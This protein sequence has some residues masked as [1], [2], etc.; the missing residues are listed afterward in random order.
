MKRAY[1]VIKAAIALIMV[2]FVLFSFVF[3]IAEADHSCAGE[4]CPICYQL[5]VCEG[6]LKSALLLAACSAAALITAQ[7]IFG[8]ELCSHSPAS[9]LSPVDLKVKL[10]D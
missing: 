8:A 1:R 6:F 5:S 2:L 4:D 10:S 7:L 9:V 3:I